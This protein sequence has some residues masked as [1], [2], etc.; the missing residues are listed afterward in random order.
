MIYVHIMLNPLKAEARK[1]LEWFDMWNIVFE[2]SCMLFVTNTVF[3]YTLVK[4][5]INWKKYI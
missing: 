3:A 2:Y 5:Q 4:L 1:Y